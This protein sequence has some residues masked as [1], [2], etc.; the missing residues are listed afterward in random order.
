MGVVGSRDLLVSARLVK[1][2]RGPL[3]TPVS[4]FVGKLDR[5]RVEG[6]EKAPEGLTLAN[7]GAGVTQAVGEPEILIYPVEPTQEIVAKDRH[8]LGR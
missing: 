2:A 8:P 3:Q 1:S 6:G 7:R 5:V 4:L